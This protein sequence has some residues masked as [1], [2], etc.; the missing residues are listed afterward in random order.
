MPSTFLTA[1]WRKLIMAQYAIDPAILTPYVPPASH[2]T[3]TA[4]ANMTVATSHWS[5]SYSTRSSSNN[6]RSHS[7]RGS[8]K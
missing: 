1:S 5:D 4:M 2:S 3:Y 8:K 7:T 6:V